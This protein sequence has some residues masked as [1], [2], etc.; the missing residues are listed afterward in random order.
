GQAAAETLSSSCSGWYGPSLSHT[1][2][3][4]HT[5]TPTQHTLRGSVRSA[6]PVVCVASAVP[7]SSGLGSVWE[8]H[9]PFKGNH[10]QCTAP[11]AEAYRTNTTS[12]GP[13]M[14]HFHPGHYFRETCLFRL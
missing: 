8:L 14:F 6:H 3:H 9:G 12:Q 7:S 11:T 2:T 5:H 1:H 13:S 4:T 10:N